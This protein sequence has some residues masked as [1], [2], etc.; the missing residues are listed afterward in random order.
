MIAQLHLKLKVRKRGRG[1]EGESI[2]VSGKVKLLEGK[3]FPIKY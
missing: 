2:P 1:P 3:P